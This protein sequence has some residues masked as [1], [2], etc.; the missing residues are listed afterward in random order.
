MLDDHV[1]G[2][3]LGFHKGGRPIHLKGAPEVEC[4]RRRGSEVWGGGFAISPEN[5][6]ISYIK[7]VRF[8]AFPVTFIDTV[9]AN[10]YERKYVLFKKFTLIKGTLDPPPS[11]GS[12]PV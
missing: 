7:M 2:A 4:R 12:A 3:D 1:P 9:T 6:C 10:R 5:L 11:P 8:Y